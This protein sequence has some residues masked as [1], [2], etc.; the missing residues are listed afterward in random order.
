MLA[1]L[2]WTEMQSYHEHQLPHYCKHLN[3]RN[4]EKGLEVNFD[5]IIVI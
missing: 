1:N 5:I 2:S 3:S 4:R